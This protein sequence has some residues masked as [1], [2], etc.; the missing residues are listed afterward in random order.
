M[1]QLSTKMLSVYLVAIATLLFAAVRI[2]KLPGSLTAPASSHRARPSVPPPVLQVVGLEEQS[3]AV[4]TTSLN[5]SLEESL[6]RDMQR[7]SHNMGVSTD[8]LRREQD[9]LLKIASRAAIFLSTFWEVVP[10][11]GGYLPG[12]RNPCWY[13][14][15]TIDEDDRTM[16]VTRLFQYKNLLPRASISALYRDIFTRHTDKPRLFCL[17]YFL[18][19]G[20]PKSGTTTLHS[21]LTHHPQVTPPEVKEL[22]WWARVPLGNMEKYLKLV[23]VRYLLNFESASKSISEDSTVITYD[24]SQSTL[25]DSNFNIDD[26]DYCAMATILHRV[27]PNA[28]ILILM[29]DPV[30]R[31]Y[32]HFHYMHET[33]EWPKEMKKS[34]QQYF[35]K[36]VSTAIGDFKQC[37]TDSSLYEC[38]N[39]KVYREQLTTWMGVGIYHVQL[40]EW[41]QLW[42][43]ENFLFLKTEQLA[44]HPLS[45]VG[46]ITTFL[47][48]DPASEETALEWLAN[49]KNV[50]HYDNML[51]ETR[52][53]LEEFY[54][55][56]NEELEK[57][58]GVTWAYSNNTQQ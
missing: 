10:R 20:F 41:M 32:S 43:R 54:A 17:P 37:L 44:T 19:A 58:V 1:P 14:N 35:H 16:L 13:A 40:L 8:V 36:Y 53:L 15:L 23:T 27:L 22:H 33:Q 28:K 38:A 51:P 12:V 26:E 24:G 50:G 34:P 57:L 2:T 9:K 18:I 52:R 47:S 30:S 55:P 21:V 5:L 48:L 39:K 56:F 29:R 42:P 6:L 4:T 25:I 49:M 11:P 31:I 45:V 7:C 3:A 46:N